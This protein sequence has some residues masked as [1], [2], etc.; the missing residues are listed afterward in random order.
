VYVP[1]IFV[2]NKI[3]EMPNYKNSIDGKFVGICASK[4]IGVDEL[5]D[6]IWR[7]L[8]FVTVYILDDAMIMKEGETLRDVALKI[9]SE[10]SQKVKFAKINGAGAKF[11]DQEVSLDTK[12]TEK[13]KI[14][15]I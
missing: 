9:G 7:E 1:A 6:Q 8:K 2:I 15:F 5:I 10:F 14:K 13:M 4:R 11:T 3:D 12:V